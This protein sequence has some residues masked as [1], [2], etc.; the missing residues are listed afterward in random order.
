V[1]TKN[2]NKI[3]CALDLMPWQVVEVEKS[4]PVDQHKSCY[5]QGSLLVLCFVGDKYITSS[6]AW[7]V[8]RLITEKNIHVVLLKK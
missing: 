7:N 6:L 2:A 1:F 8:T 3:H 4:A 5:L